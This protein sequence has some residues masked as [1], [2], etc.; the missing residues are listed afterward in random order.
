MIGRVLNT[1]LISSIVTARIK[2]GQT[3]VSTDCRIR[4]MICSKAIS[5]SKAGTHCKGFH[6]AYAP[7]RTDTGAQFSRRAQLKTSLIQI[8]MT[9]QNQLKQVLPSHLALLDLFVLDHPRKAGQ[10]VLIRQRQPV[11]AYFAASGSGYSLF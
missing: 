1:K 4:P 3:T 9:V 2:D 6:V 8:Q 7:N 11:S 5:I 10:A